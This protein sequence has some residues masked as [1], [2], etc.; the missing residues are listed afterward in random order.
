MEWSKQFNEV[1]WAGGSYCIWDI[2]GSLLDLGVT[3]S[4]LQSSPQ[5]SQR[6]AHT[7]SAIK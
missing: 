5:E 2:L 3:L 7:S 6:M 4:N 1:A